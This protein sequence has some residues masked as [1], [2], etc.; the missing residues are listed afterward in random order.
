MKSPLRTAPALGAVR[1]AWL[2]PSMKGGYYWQ[3]LFREFT[4]LLPNSVTFTS[5]WPGFIK[6]HEGVFGLRV[7]PGLRFVALGRTGRGSTI[8]FAWAPL[9][10]F[11]ELLKFRPD[12]LFASAFTVWTLLGLVCKAI[13][14]ARVILLWDGVTE[15]TARRQSR[16]ILTVRKVM[17]R[18]VD[19]ALCNSSEGVEYLRDVI[20]IPE[21]RLRHQ[22]FYVPDVA[23]MSLGE[24]TRSTSRA[25][26]HCTFLFV[27][28]IIKGKGWRCLLKA[29][30]QLVQEGVEAF[31]VSVVGE[32]EEQ[33]L[34]QAGIRSLALEEVVTVVGA[35]PY[36][37][38]GAHFEA[39]D[40]FVLPTLE[41]TWGVVVSEAMAFGKAV[42]CSKYAG[43]KELVKGGVNGFVF[44]PHDVTELA[45]QMKRFI[46]E[47]HLAEEFGRHSREIV[48]PYTPERAARA[49]AECILGVVGGVEGSSR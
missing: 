32:G 40:V 25:K 41:D 12:A 7:L 1:V 2:V 8:G 9:S 6:G 14:R 15:S 36:E 19:A 4:K 11:R 34:L 30:S 33:D 28:K 44:D 26:S 48:A 13:C 45:G 42:L 16:V 49:L 35:I 3:P 37:Q 31:S 10:V 39:A 5:D 21:A 38:L 17:A 22:A 27:G 20:K 18:F 46:R 29:A 24:E 23:A 43:A 47:P